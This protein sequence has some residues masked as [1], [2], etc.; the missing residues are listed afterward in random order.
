MPPRAK[1]TDEPAAPDLD[2]SGGDRPVGDP[3]DGNVTLAVRHP[4][5]SLTLGEDF[6]GLEITSAG[7]EVPVDQEK[8]IRA[9]ADAAGVRIRK[10]K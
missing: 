6:D 1:Q 10:V 4:H 5:D 8:A 3:A 2:P 7:T 9:A